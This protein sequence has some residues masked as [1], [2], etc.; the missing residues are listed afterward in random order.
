MELTNK[1][2]AAREAEIEALKKTLLERES[3]VTAND[4]MDR[5][6]KHGNRHVISHC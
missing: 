1:R 3:L 6:L 5:E 2:L 4:K